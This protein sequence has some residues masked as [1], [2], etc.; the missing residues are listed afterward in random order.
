M[1]TSG[2]DGRDAVGEQRPEVLVHELGW[3]EDVG[4]VLAAVERV[5]GRKAYSLRAGHEVIDAA[6]LVHHE[7]EALG[8]LALQT[9]RPG[10]RYAAVGSRVRA[11]RPVAL[12]G[13]RRERGDAVREQR[14]EV[15]VH[16]LGCSED[17]GHILPVAQRVEGRDVP[18]LRAGREV[19]DAAPC[20]DD[21]AE[22]N[23]DVA[24]QAVR[25][26]A[27]RFLLAEPHPVDALAAAVRR[28]HGHRDLGEVLQGNLVALGSLVGIGR[29]DVDHRVVL[30][31][32]G[33]DRR[34][35]DAVVHDGLVL[36][37][38][39][40]VEPADVDAAEGEGGEARVD[41]IRH[42]VAVDPGV[43]FV[44][45]VH[46]VAVGPEA[47]RAVVAGLR[48]LLELLVTD[49]LEVLRFRVFGRRPLGCGQAVGEEPLGAV[50]G[51]PD[52]DA[53]GPD[54]VGVVVGGGELVLGE[55]LAAREVVGEEAVLPAVEHPHRLPVGPDTARI[56]VALGQRDV[57]VREALAAREV[58]GEEP[59]AVAVGDPGG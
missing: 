53:V 41:G 22:A 6:A 25:G 16:E 38:T 47:A 34:L 55:Q 37:T 7:V 19:L 35:R 33:G 29:V 18:A 51:D 50:V 26:G 44:G 3:S 48:Q 54:A 32:L 36:R 8:D 49:A 5:E 28:G 1:T 58:V 11:G 4:D 30:R 13:Q 9:R 31:S 57:R 39:A 43:A 12:D 14:P 21:E 46:H 17:V 42:V 15:L 20:V 24:A 56:A 40:A 2:S 27:G 45:D 10:L 59:L 52:G 23:G